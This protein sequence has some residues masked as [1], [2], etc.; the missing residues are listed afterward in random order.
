M[1]TSLKPGDIILTSGTGIISMLIRKFSTSRNEEPTLINHVGMVLSYGRNPIILEALTR[2][3][4]HHLDKAYLD[5]D[6]KIT[7]YRLKGLTDQE[8]NALS[9][10]VFH[11]ANRPYGFFKLIPHLLDALCGNRY[12]FRRMLLIENY[13]ICSWLV[14]FAYK[15][16]LD[17]EFG[18]HYRA[19]QPDDIYDFVTTSDKFECIFP[20]GLYRG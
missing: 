6:S 8:C 19:A 5:S 20:L 9:D 18:I 12:I 10:S 13:P 16:V 2:V 17:F 11:Y 3:R 14:A 15:K 7:I 4:L 1:D